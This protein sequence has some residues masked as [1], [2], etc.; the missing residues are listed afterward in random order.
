VRSAGGTRYLKQS[1]YFAGNTF[2]RLAERRRDAQWLQQQLDENTARVLPVWRGRVLVAMEND[3][4]CMVSVTHAQATT[5]IGNDRL[6]LLGEF[7]NQL[8]F[9]AELSDDAE[10]SFDTPAQ[11]HDLRSMSGLLQRDEAGLL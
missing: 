6:I 5:S 11:F 2:N 3:A 9:A 10:P 8:Y 1:H 4:P 7:R